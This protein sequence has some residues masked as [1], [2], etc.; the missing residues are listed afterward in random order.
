[1][2]SAGSMPLLIQ[3]SSFAGELA[4]LR[5]AAGDFDRRIRA[6]ELCARATANPA[7]GTVVDRI[8]AMTTELFHA[9]VS[10]EAEHDPDNP[11][12]PWL[13]FMVDSKADIPT[14]LRLERVWHERA[15]KI[16]PDDPLGYRLGV[17][18]LE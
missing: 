12:E 18:P 4:Q 16:V 6:L 5:A 14:I 10:V 2:M 11:R 3:D 8:V 13:V 9:P 1:M 15:A 17:N 7:D